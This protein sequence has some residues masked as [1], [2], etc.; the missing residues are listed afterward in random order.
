MVIAIPT[1][2]VVINPYLLFKASAIKLNDS[3]GVPFWLPVICQTYTRV[4]PEG[5]ADLLEGSWLPEQLQH[6]LGQQGVS[7]S[8]FH[9]PPPVLDASQ[10]PDAGDVIKWN[11]SSKLLRSL[12]H[13]IIVNHLFPLVSF[14]L[15]L[16]L[17]QLIFFF[18]LW[19]SFSTQLESI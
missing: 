6:L 14:A 19:V 2:S 11:E 12:A 1:N 3:F 17:L 18:P 5:K 4:A 15:S 13:T 16:W 10:I 8:R 9:Q 7:A